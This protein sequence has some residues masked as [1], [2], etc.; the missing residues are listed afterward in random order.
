[1]RTWLNELGSMWREKRSIHFFFKKVYM[2]RRQKRLRS[3]VIFFVVLFRI[4]LMRPFN[5]TCF[6]SRNDVDCRRT[7][8]SLW[9]RRITERW[10]NINICSESYH[11]FVTEWEFWILLHFFIVELKQWQTRIVLSLVPQN[12]RTIG[13]FKLNQKQ[14]IWD[15]VNNFNTFQ[16]FVIHSRADERGSFLNPRVV[17]M[18]W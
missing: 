6:V 11:F 16:I 17:E 5:D 13:K 10:V 15:L 4:Q 14:I 2:K 18:T 3:D 8:S 9:S 1:M 12:S 7:R